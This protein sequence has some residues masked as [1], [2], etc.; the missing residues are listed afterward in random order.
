M[1]LWFAGLS[2]VLVWAVFQSPALDYRLVM[3]GSVLQVGEVVLGGPRLLHTL[4]FAAV[5]LFAIVAATPNKRLLRR[6]LIGLP[7]G[8]LMHLLLDGIWATR[9]VF[10]W[11][12]FGTDFGAGQVPEL[13]RG[14]AVPLALDA[15]GLVC[16]VWA[17]KRFGLD[18]PTRRSRFFRTGQLTREAVT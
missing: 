17:W 13:D 5:V 15:I 1:I 6:R 2:L 18:D 9:E 16:L 11:P 7:I 10:W 14:W 12:F 3:L 8:L 4:V